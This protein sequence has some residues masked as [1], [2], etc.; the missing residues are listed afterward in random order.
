M[1]AALDPTGRPIRVDDITIRTPGLSGTIVTLENPSK[2]RTRGA[3]GVT[4]ELDSALRRG[5]MRTTHL[6]S[7]DLTAQRRRGRRGAATRGDGPRGDSSDIVLDV[8]EPVKGWEQVVLS[9]D[10]HGVMSWHFAAKPEKAAPG[11]RRTRGAARGK[12]RYVIQQPDVARP[13]R[14]DGTSTTRSLAGEIGKRVVKVI[15]FKVGKY[16]GKKAQELAR[17]WERKNR[18]DG[19]RSFEPATIAELVPYYGAA[20]PAWKNLAKGRALLFIHGTFGRTHSAMASFPRPML[21]RLHTAYGGRVFAF[22]HRTVSDDPEVNV[23]WFLDQVP[24]DVKLELDVVCHSRGGLV[25]RTLAERGKELG[26]ERVRVRRIALVAVPSEGTILASVENWNRLLDTFTSVVNMAG[27]PGVGDFIDVILT[28]V[29]QIVLTGYEEIDG[30]HCMMPGSDFLTVLN[31][32]KRSGATYF[33]LASNFEP[34]GDDFAALVQD[35]ALDLL[36]GKPND[37]MVTIPSATGA[38]ADGRKA[39]F[40]PVDE[41]FVLEPPGSIEHS[42][43]FGR[44]DLMDRL[45]GW[46]EA[47][48]R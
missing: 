34:A 19:I 30:L 10:K 31:T 24:R 45:V 33:A 29:R 11:A 38:P 7:M 48:V 5:G 37:L 9:V 35:E 32:Q 18:P 23:R 46:L 2:A 39:P 8:P 3:A 22:D 20:D 1:Q 43:Y 42:S 27:G 12:R 44:A 15:A 25:A 47:G 6:V 28:A 21:E 14:R 16:V 40:S 17:D 4:S 13:I 26:G 36:H 41:Q